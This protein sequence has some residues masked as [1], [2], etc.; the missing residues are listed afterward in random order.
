MGLDLSVSEFKYSISDTVSISEYSNRIFMMSI[1]N[2][3]LFGVVTLSVFESRQKYKN[4]YNINDIRPYPI[5]FHPY[6]LGQRKR[7]EYPSHETKSL[8]YHFLALRVATHASRS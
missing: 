1:S 4:K 6:C 3:I 8:A 7:P 2:H 5:H